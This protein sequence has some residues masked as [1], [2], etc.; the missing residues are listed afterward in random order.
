M[1]FR[2]GVIDARSWIVKNH[3]SSRADGLCDICFC[4]L[5]SFIILPHINIHSN[6][7]LCDMPIGRRAALYDLLMILSSKLIV[8]IR[9]C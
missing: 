7:G 6:Y 4:N 3:V 5:V 8:D 2:A 1:A 9:M